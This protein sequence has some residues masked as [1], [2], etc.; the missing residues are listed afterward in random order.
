V[1]S[2]TAAFS[3]AQCC[4]EAIDSLEVLVNGDMFAL[5]Q[6]RHGARSEVTYRKYYTNGSRPPGARSVSKDDLLSFPSPFGSGLKLRIVAVTMKRHGRFLLHTLAWEGIFSG[7]P[8]SSSSNQKGG[9]RNA[10]DE[11]VE[12]K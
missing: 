2:S 6:S 11:R 7:H 1:V 3:H 8:D 4:A 10:D 12:V 5:Y 9:V